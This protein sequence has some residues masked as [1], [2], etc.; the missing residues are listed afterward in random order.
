[1]ADSNPGSA[2]RYSLT[3]RSV[4]SRTD[5]TSAVWDAR[6]APTASLTI[7]FAGFLVIV[8]RRARPFWKRGSSL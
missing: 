3:R 6:Y 8:P 4:V 2:A 1:M 5:S 7:R